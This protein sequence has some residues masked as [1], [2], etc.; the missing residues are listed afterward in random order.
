MFNSKKT[1]I[2]LVEDHEMV[3]QGFKA[4]LSSVPELEI[5]GEADNGIQAVKSILELKPD[6]VFLDLSLP[7]R[8]GIC[9][10]EEVKK[11]NP[12]TKFIILTAHNT[13]EHVHACFGAGASGFVSKSACFN[14]I[15]MA[16]KSILKGKTFISPEVASKVIDGY[17]D[18][19]KQECNTTRLSTLTKREKEVLVL[20]A[21]GHKS[22]DIAE[23][24]FISLKTVERHRA[25]LMK[26]LDL[27]N[28]AALTSY[29]IQNKLISPENL[30]PLVDEEN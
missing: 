2:V 23:S 26:K 16:I 3:R 27:H 19:K 4:L 5:I 14:E 20:I 15:E 30:T 7:K 17:L 8:N 25:N 9:V 1:R 11:F 29:A 6:L 10:I 18:G 13:D 21:E 24:L 28:S 22:R 12:L